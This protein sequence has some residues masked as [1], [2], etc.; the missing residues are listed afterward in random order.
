MLC[1][2]YIGL[3]GY[4]WDMILYLDK[5]VE[6]FMVFEWVYV[7]FNMIFLFILVFLSGLYI[8]ELYWD[9]LYFIWFGVDNEF[10]VE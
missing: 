1:Y 6:W 4:E 3:G 9:S 8:I 2:D 7:L 10:V 5:L